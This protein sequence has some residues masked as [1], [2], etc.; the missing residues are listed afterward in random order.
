MHVVC[1]YGNLIPCTNDL[2]DESG[3]VYMS[4][5]ELVQVNSEVN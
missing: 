3:A 1:I 5:S 2:R 4:A